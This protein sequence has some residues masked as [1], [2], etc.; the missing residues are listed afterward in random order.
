MPTLVASGDAFPDALAA[1]P[2][3]IARG[4]VLLLTPR[5][6]V[7]APT[8]TFLRDTDIS[9]LRIAGGTAAVSEGVGAQLAN[10]AGVG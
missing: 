8:E 4:G 2:A 6:T 9:R 1:G 10:A 7:G 5:D 3:A